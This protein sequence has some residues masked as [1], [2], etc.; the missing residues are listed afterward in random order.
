MYDNNLLLKNSLICV[1]MNSLAID[2]VPLMLQS[3]AYSVW[4]LSTAISLSPC[5]FATMW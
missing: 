1:A 3:A 4:Q 2:T 5:G